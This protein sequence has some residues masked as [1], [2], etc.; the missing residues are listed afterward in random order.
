MSNLTF[1]IGP[2]AKHSLRKTSPYAILLLEISSGLTSEDLASL[3]LAIQADK[4]APR[5][6]VCHLKHGADVIALFD[7]RSL[8]SRTCTDFLENLLIKIGRKD[9]QKKIIKYHE[10]RIKDVSDDKENI[11]KK[12]GTQFTQLKSTSDQLREEMKYL[13]IETSVKEVFDPSARSGPE[14]S[15]HCSTVCETSDAQAIPEA[16]ESRQGF[17]SSPMSVDSSQGNCTDEE[18][19]GHLGDKVWLFENDAIMSSQ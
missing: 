19:I 6:E 10:H 12:I 18:K 7:K 13:S 11:N 3:K 14:G 15:S 17:N 2:A 5:R 8:I 1:K 16:I 9:L 4:L